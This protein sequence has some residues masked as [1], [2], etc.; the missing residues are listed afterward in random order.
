MSI[1]LKSWLRKKPV[2][3]KLRFETDDGTKELLV[4][5]DG[6]RRFANAANAI[7]AMS[8]NGRLEALDANGVTLRLTEIRAEEEPAEEDA[9]PSIKDLMK[10]MGT[11]G[12]TMVSLLMLFS[13]LIAEAAD[14][15]AQRH[16]EAYSLA[17]DKQNELLTI[18]ATRL[19]GMERAWQG[20]L[21]KL[22]QAAQGD[23]GEGTIKEMLAAMLMK[24]GGGLLPP[25]KTP[26]APPN[27]AKT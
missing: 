14:K 21:N 11:E 18:V 10:G 7:L 8:P 27:G 6:A 23:D 22:G 1:N 19:V 26:P 2:P 24:Q 15:G 13:K 4:E 25:K 17:F 5:T 3:V 16:A 12:N 9:T 20:A